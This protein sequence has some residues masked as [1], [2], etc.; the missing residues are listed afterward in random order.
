MIGQTLSRYRIL[1]KLG[2][3]G[4][5]VVYKAHDSQLDRVVALK[6]LPLD[7]V[8]DQGRRKRFYEEARSASALSHPNIA[9]I[10][11]A[12]EDGGTLFIAM[13]F[14]EGETL[15]QL[16][17]AGRLPLKRA[18]EIA[19]QVAEG[20]A[21][22][23]SRGVVHRDIK[24]ENIMV[25]PDGLAKIIDFG[26]A[27][28]NEA[29]GGPG[30]S[31]A[32]ALATNTRAGT[33]L[34]TVYY[35]SPE[36]AEGKPADTRS[37]IF[38]FGGVLYEMLA[39]QQPF[40]GTSSVDVLHAILRR[41]PKPLAELDPSLPAEL[42]RIVEECLAK[43]AEERFQSAKDVALALKRERRTL[44]SGERPLPVVASARRARRSWLVAALGLAGIGLVAALALLRSGP[45]QAP[46]AIGTV[47]PL[48]SFVGLEWLPSWSPDGTF[49]TY[50]H[51]I[52]GSMDVFV[53]PTAGG[54]PVRL[55]DGPADDVLPR[56]SPDGRYIAFLTDPGTG[57]NVYVMPSLGG[58]QRKLGEVR[59]PFLERTFDALR[60]LGAQPWSPD[61]QELLFSRLESAGQ[62]TLWKVEVGTGQQTQLTHPPPGTDDVLASWSFDGEWIAFE[63]RHGGRGAIWLLPVSGP[64]PKA[65][66]DDGFYNGQPAWS[67]DDEDI[68]FVSN[69][70]GSQ[71]IWEIDR[72]S[73]AM[74]Q[75]TTGP[76]QD[77]GPVVG[78]HGALAYS[79]FSHQT[80]LYV[81]V[82]GS[83]QERRLTSNTRDNFGARFSPDGK[84]IVYHSDRTGNLEIWL[85]ELDTGVERQ[86]TDDPARDLL[87]DFSPDRGE[88]VFL[89]DREGNF[90]LL[91]MDSE[92][93][94]VRRISQQSILL[95]G[96]S[97]PSLSQAPRWSPDG[98][99]IG[100]LA[101]SDDGPGL[102]LVQPDG[103]DPRPAL[104]GV[105]RFDWYRDSRHVVQTRTAA[106][107]SGTLEMHVTDL[108]TGEDELLLTGPNAEPVVAPDGRA[109]L[110]CQAISHFG[111]QFFVLR[112][113]L[114]AEPDGLPRPLGPP[115]QLTRATDPSHV[116]TGGWSPD[117]KTIV[118]T[119]DTD[120]GDLY[121]IENF[122]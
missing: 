98:K 32:S 29:L 37:D 95:P 15:R 88:I 21:R 33:I 67:P 74:R 35:M 112:L 41:E 16:L 36:Q 24:P 43:D 4:M 81:M 96:G 25:A 77:W 58:T 19:I 40:L 45:E 113:A 118:Y 42:S 106:D 85:F 80:D 6:V 49:V 66:L 90:H 28:R 44:E 54:E 11:E 8:K 114:P 1:E 102:W 120:Q 5:G 92:G 86:L 18:L 9:T 91:A 109:I 34:G 59:F 104:S 116:H 94:A 12:A 27:K 62:V 73:R 71:N 2:E 38:S 20:L 23:H 110:Y 13:E 65:F 93:S 61:G 101:M 69:R 121:V 17:S 75:V 122:R 100:Y 39:G 107:G 72:A 99:A 105:L 3:G 7:L 97:A 31:D 53:M 103:G 26:L 76:G 50:S 119:R 115:E 78:R 14:V 52:H 10:Y 55:T 47:K 84:Q 64:E 108:E 83:D 48:T 56:W 89:S 60:A 30:G 79:P 46:V 22:A 57:S 117:G 87:P 82:V 63:R 70:G 51:N 68:V 111:M